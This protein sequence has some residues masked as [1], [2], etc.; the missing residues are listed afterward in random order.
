MTSNDVRDA[1]RD[2]SA[3]GTSLRIV[4]SGTWLGA[5]R[6]VH[7]ARTLSVTNLTGVVHYEPGDFT[8]TARAGTT[9]EELASLTLPN[10]QFL[11]LDPF[12]DLEGTLG[13]TVA[14]G[15]SGPMAYAFGGPRDN[16]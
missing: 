12:G 5:G 1:V 11:A 10:R 3:A 13:A 15:A 8:L 16:A 7:A 2:A 6:P 9:L 14:T 4:G